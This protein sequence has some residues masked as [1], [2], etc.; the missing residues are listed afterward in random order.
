VRDRADARDSSEMR[1][2]LLYGLGF[3]HILEHLY[4]LGFPPELVHSPRLIGTWSLDWVKLNRSLGME[5]P[6]GVFMAEAGGE[7]SFC[8]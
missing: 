3:S 1:M 8:I 2:R 6:N 7:F 4:K 5:I